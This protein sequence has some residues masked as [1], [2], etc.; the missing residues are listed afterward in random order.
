VAVSPRRRPDSGLD[1]FLV[2]D[3]PPGP[4]SEQ[5]LGE[6]RRVLG[7]A[8]VGHAGT[9]DPPASGLVG[10][11]CGAATRLARFA[12]EGWKTYRGEL[13]LGTATTTLDD[14]GDV[15]AAGPPDVDPARLRA[16][17]ASLV[18]E[19]SQVPPMISAVHVA[20][21]RL[22]ELARDGREVDRPPR[23]VS[24][25]RFELAG[26]LDTG[27][28]A[29]E[30]TCSAGTYVRSLADEAARRAGTVGH[31]R[32]L[33]RVGVGPFGLAES[34]TLEEL[35]ARGRAAV[36]PM[37]DAVPLLPRLRLDAGELLAFRQGRAVPVRALEP[38]PRED[39]FG[40][41]PPE[42][43]GAVSLAAPVAVLGPDGRLYGV[44][45]LD[46]DDADGVP[47]GERSGTP[48]LARPAVVLGR[49]G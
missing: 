32:R 48:P 11:L 22:Y 9:L 46:V 33:R 20:G 36:R 15:V 7:Q 23:R 26:E 14:T 40:P 39:P 44:A 8:R 18:G 38:P 43:R 1:G 24:V 5:V 10:V 31:L 2:V 41:H 25:L 17:V 6:C 37:G 45:E 4:T 16:A 30:V 47:A 19:V 3:K 12:G 21:R 28:W 34:V 29:L 27:V 13:V 49:P 42:T 35:R